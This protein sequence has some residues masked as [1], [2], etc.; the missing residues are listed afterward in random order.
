MVML[1]RRKLAA[2]LAAQAVAFVVVLVIGVFTGHTSKAA[3]APTSTR[4][5]KVTASAR[6]TPGKAGRD[7]LTV[8]VV[9][10]TAAGV[11]LK[12]SPVSVLQDGNLASVSTGVLD[13][14][15]EYPASVAAGQYQVCV[16]PSFGWI[17]KDRGT[18]SLGDWICMTAD[19]GTA[20]ATVTFRLASQ[21]AG[22]GQ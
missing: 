3:P 20:P 7:N 14:S 21:F 11:S 10:L 5:P 18:Q 6:A 22:G 13:S 16:N 2:P 9:Q 4:T 8:R 12:G 17:S 15:L 19:V 1:D